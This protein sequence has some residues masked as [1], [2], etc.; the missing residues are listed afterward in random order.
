LYNRRH[1]GRVLEQ[2]FSEASRYGDDLA[3]VMIDLDGYKPINDAF[4]HAVGDQLLVVAGEGHLGQHAPDGRR[5]ALR[6]R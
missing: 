1:F 2:L 3:C 4:G 5:R 6:R